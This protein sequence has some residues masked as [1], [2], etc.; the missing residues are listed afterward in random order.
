MDGV[1]DLGGK[2]GMGP[3]DPTPVEEDPV[4]HEVWERI[5][6][7]LMPQTLAQEMF[8]IDEF[9]HAIERMQPVRYLESGYYEHWLVALETLLVEKEILSNKELQ[10]RINELESAEDP[11]EHIPERED[12][13]LVKAMMELIENGASRRRESAEPAFEPGDEVIVKN[14]HPEGH[15]RCA[16]YIRHARGVIDEVRGTFVLPDT[17]AHGEGENPEPVYSVRFEAEELWGAAAEPNEAVY[18][19]AWESYLQEG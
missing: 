12:P 8:N 5:V 18:F 13:Q 2:A 10:S 6:F 1:H 11:E 16:G 7:G 15:T 4:F 19:D 14:M 3:V 17:D 9:R